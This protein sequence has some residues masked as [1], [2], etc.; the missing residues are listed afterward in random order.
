MYKPLLSLS[1]LLSASFGLGSSTAGMDPYQ[2]LF[3]DS[4][5][6]LCINQKAEP[7]FISEESELEIKKLALS[8]SQESSQVNHDECLHLIT[9]I[10]DDGKYIVLED[11]SIWLVGWFYRNSV[12]R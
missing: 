4:N 7:I 2:E 3:G 12:C 11:G 9:E 1:L 10:R 5:P 8:L 6:L